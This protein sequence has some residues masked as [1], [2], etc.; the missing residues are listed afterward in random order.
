MKQGGIGGMGILFEHLEQR[1]DGFGLPA[2]G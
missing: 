2:A 1:I